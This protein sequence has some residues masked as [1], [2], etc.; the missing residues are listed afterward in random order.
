MGKNTVN[1]GQMLEN[2]ARSGATIKSIAPNVLLI[3]TG[4]TMPNGNVQTRGE[5]K[6][7][8]TVVDTAQRIMLGGCIKN[9]QGEVIS[10]VFMKYRT[11][12]A[13][14]TL[15][16]MEQRSFN[17]NDPADSRT[18]SITSTSFSNMQVVVH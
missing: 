1:I 11:D 7:V 4:V 15:E 9:D 5:H 18:V 2:A 16:L 8:E 12:T 13:T 14:P 6:I 10:Q 3:T 17:L